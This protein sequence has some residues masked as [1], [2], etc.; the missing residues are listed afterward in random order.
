MANAELFEPGAKLLRAFASRRAVADETDLTEHALQSL[1][2]GDLSHLK[3]T[4]QS[5]KPSAQIRRPQRETGRI[6]P[7]G[8]KSSAKDP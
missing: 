4:L 3:H 6:A 2:P 5:C 8:R 7:T 1:A